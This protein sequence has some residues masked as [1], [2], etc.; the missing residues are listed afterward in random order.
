[1]GLILGGWLVGMIIIGAMA[2]ENF[3][4]IDRLLE[5]P[6]HPRFHEA[7][8]QLPEGQ[9]RLMMRYLSSELNRFWFRAWEWVELVFGIALLLLS[10]GRPRRRSIVIACSL[11]LAVVLLTAFYLTPEIVDIGRQ[12][13]FVPRDPEPPAL[14]QFGRLH[15][16]YS[17]L[18]VFKLAVGIWMAVALLRLQRD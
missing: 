5:S 8:A 12:L 4:M 18:D 11:M 3:W 10:L 7:V 1:M 13:D 14:E 2:A 15:A 9:A 16:A 17:M 6:S